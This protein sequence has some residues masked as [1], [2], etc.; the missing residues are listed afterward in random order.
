V[1]APTVPT[2]DTLE[3]LT[4]TKLNQ[5]GDA[6][7][8]Q[9]AADGIYTPVISA[10]GGTPAV[11]ASGFLTGKWWRHS[12]H[13]TAVIDLCISGAGSSLAGTS[14]RITLPFVADLTFHKANVLN[15]ESDCIGNFQTH[16]TVSADARTGSCL[17]S[18]PSG[19]DTTGD[20]I[21]FY[22][23]GSTGSLGTGNF[24]TTGR[25]KAIVS[26]VADPTAI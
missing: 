9:V 23:N 17:L 21:V 20:A 10:A 8:F 1:T 2:F 18:G 26:Y 25:V 5:L 6:V 22:P 4:A 14:W 15:A 19:T 13:V 7:E 24:T 3:R 11:G 12:N 16:T